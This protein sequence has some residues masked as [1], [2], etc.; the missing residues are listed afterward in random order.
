MNDAAEAIAPIPMQRHPASMAT[1]RT[2]KSVGTRMDSPF[3]QDLRAPGKTAT[4]FLPID[5]PRAGGSAF[6]Q[7]RGAQATTGVGKKGGAGRCAS[8]Y[9]SRLGHDPA[10]RAPIAQTLGSLGT[11]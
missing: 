8:G 4:P 7:L 1:A 9:A 10:R 2:S 5:H 11:F 3:P 6:L